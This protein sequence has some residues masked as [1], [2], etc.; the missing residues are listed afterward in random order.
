MNKQSEKD[1]TKYNRQYQ[2]NL[3]ARLVLQ[4][5]GPLMTM[6]E[7]QQEAERLYTVGV[8]ASNYFN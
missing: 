3:L 1:D 7:A 5:G 8:R 6:L 2:V 4:Q